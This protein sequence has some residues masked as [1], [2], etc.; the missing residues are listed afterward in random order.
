MSLPVPLGVRIYNY[1][2]LGLDRWITPWVSDLSFRSVIPGGFASA[3]I[4][5]ARPRM[6]QTPEVITGTATASG[7]SATPDYLVCSDADAAD[8]SVG[9]RV[10]I[11]DASLNIR[12]GGAR[13]RVT[14]KVSAFGF[15]NVSFTPNASGVTNTG[16]VMRAATPGHFSYADPVVFDE[17]TNLFNR[18]QIVDLRTGEIVWEGRVEDPQRDSGDDTWTL[19]CLGAMIVASDIQRPMWY[20][21]G[22]VSNWST[23][24]SD[25]LFTFTTD[26]ENNWIRVQMA[27]EELDGGPV[28]PFNDYGGSSPLRWGHC[29]ETDTYIGRF[30]ITYF[31]FQFS[32]YTGV[33]GT[34][35]TN[36]VNTSVADG[37]WANRVFGIDLTNWNTSPSTRKANAINGATSFTGTAR[38]WIFC[39]LDATGGTTGYVPWIGRQFFMIEDPRIQVL[40]M[41]VTSTMLTAAADYPNDFVTVPQIVRD[42]VGRFLV[43]GWNSQ[44]PASPVPFRGQVRTTDIHVDASSTAEI[45][46]LT[47]YDGATAAT[48]LGDM[49]NAQPDAY[50]AI[51]ESNFRATDGVNGQLDHGFRFEWATWPG[52][53]GY[54]IGSAD[55]LSEQPTGDGIY[56]YVFHKYQIDS[57]WH[58]WRRAT[59]WW[60]T[61]SGESPTLEDG[62]VT[63]MLTV[64]NEN[65]IGDTA[66]FNKAVALGPLY[67]KRRNAG[68]VTV[69]RPIHFHDSGVTSNGGASRTLDPWQIRPGKLARITD[70]PVAA[71]MNEFV[72]PIDAFAAD[73]FTRSASSAWDDPDIGPTWVTSGGSASD[74]SVTGSRG[75]QAQTS[76]NILREALLPLTLV[77]GDL[78]VTVSTSATATG[79]GHVI[80][81]I[82]RYADS[83]NYLFAQVHFTT[84][85][86]VELSVRKIVAG[87]VTTLAS[88]T[89]VSGLTHGAGTQFRVRFGW[90]GSIVR[91]KIWLAS[92]TEPASWTVST[93]D[94]TFTGPGQVAF[95]SRLESGNTNTLPVNVEYDNFQVTGVTDNPGSALDGVAYRVVATEYRASDNSC[96]LE[97]DQVT[98]WRTETQIADSAAKK[99]TLVVKG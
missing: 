62:S 8:I 17:L 84:T 33:P 76:V 29:E 95:R 51:W 30:D 7:D 91:A 94:T 88:Q 23:Y 70:V 59:Q 86:T 5:M 71:R 85:Q 78:Y 45:K 58:H 99:S 26:Q 31:G 73:T 24:E 19:G 42:V 89:P 48:I 20:V 47:Y 97:L 98:T 49:M 56:N 75:R 92:G 4:K 37:N 34:M 80:R 28:P 67:S 32:S 55:G 12:F 25:G 68:T 65:V 74:H 96:T 41:D 40:R 38:Q 83:S 69:K 35:P 6:M 43:G 57:Q 11:Y 79:A 13:F 39:G 50:W 87:S 81:A 15:T 3:T 52:G 14:G 77:D 10:W 1:G 16:D 90:T 54:Q 21:D 82:G 63:R 72:H 9:D 64:I 2:R 46:H 53:W 36:R 27:Y 44:F 18:V 60:A 61:Q 22:D 93:T 66:A